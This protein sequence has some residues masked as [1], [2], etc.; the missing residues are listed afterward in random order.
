MANNIGIRDAAGDSRELKTTES[1]G[2]HTPH[3]NVDNFSELTGPIGATDDAA[4]GSDTE[5][6][7]L[8]SLWKRGL[9]HLSA[10]IALLPSS[11]GQK[12][13][14]GSLS[15]ALASDDAGVVLL[16]SIA[17]RHLGATY[18]SL[19]T[20]ITLGGTAQQVAAANASRRYFAFYNDSDTTM[21]INPDGTASA[22]AGIP[23]PPGA[24]WEPVPPPLNAV[25]VFCLTTGKRFQAYQG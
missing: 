18:T 17:E 14:A 2:T 5:T 8:I 13:K 21:R 7:S 6:A 4:A 12:A 10:L 16:T 23:F 25:S 9:Q 11:I 20:T 22:T 3:H 1:G 19:G 15:V 24:V